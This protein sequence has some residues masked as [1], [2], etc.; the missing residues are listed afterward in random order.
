MNDANRRGA[1]AAPHPAAVDAGM[2]VLEDGGTALEAAVAADAVLCVVYPHM[3]SIG[4]DLFAVVHRRG[5]SVVIN[6][7]GRAP[8]ALDDEAISAA[9][10]DR[11]RWLRGPHT[12]TVPGTVAA[13]QELADL[14][15]GA[16]GP[17]LEPAIALAASGC[18]VAPSLARAL[19]AERAL[20]AADPGCRAVLLGDDGSA[21]AA[22][23]VLRQPAL[24]A[25]L[26]TI[27]QDGA[28]DFYRGALA[29]QIAAGL[30]QLGSTLTAD[31]LA[32]HH[33]TLEQPLRREVSI[34]G[35]Q[36]ELLTAPPNS[37]GVLW[38]ALV[39]RLADVDPDPLDPVTA[40]HACHAAAS[41]GRWRDASLG[42]PEHVAVDV[43]PLFDGAE[44]DRPCGSVGPPQG[45]GDTVAVVAMDTEGTA[46]SL[47]QSVFMP[48]GVGLLDPSTGILMQ[49]RGACFSRDPRHANALRPGARPAHSLAPV[50]VHR[51]GVPVLVAGTMGGWGQPQILAQLTAR[52]IGLGRSV[53]DAVHAP[54]YV[55]DP[56]PT[57]GDD[58]T[59][60]VERGID[61]AVLEALVS[62]GFRPMTVD[63]RH[64]DLG[65]A[66]LIHLDGALRAASD[67]RADG[68]ARWS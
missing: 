21:P 35:D 14:G 12:M 8:A 27:A 37:Q 33:S 56:T 49:N 44:E 11:T 22:G 53:E 2:R 45:G 25:T 66:Q 67:P 30:A 36:H 34:A 23:T 13:W 57:P 7:S 40:V 41:V 39:E 24:A 16:L 58:W 15:D 62:A 51:G 64:D 10:Q 18:P 43:T 1:I 68:H 3:C 63:R 61:A 26:R 38:A 47:I 55:L 20:L 46:V 6:G 4:G 9:R 48:F 60:K 28:G 59:V 54:R 65:H 29:Q 19:Q 42:D 52:V 32:A 17:L 31:D 5:R 50:M